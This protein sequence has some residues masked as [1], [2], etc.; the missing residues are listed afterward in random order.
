LQYQAGHTVM[1]QSAGKPGHV[2]ITPVFWAPSGFSFSASYTS[3]IDHYLSDVA[4]ASGTTGNVFAVAT[5]YY[6]QVNGVTQHI[7]YSVSAGSE[8]DVSDPFPAPDAG[9]GCPTTLPA[10][11]NVCVGDAGMRAELAAKGLTADDA[12]MYMVFLPQ[13][14]ETCSPEDQPPVMCSTDP[15][16]P[17]NAF[18][19][20]HSA[21]PLNGQPLVYANMPYAVVANCGD[22]AYGPQAPNG[23][24]FA[25]AEVSVISHEANE[26]ITDW[27]GGT[28]ADAQGLEEGDECAFIFGN[29]LGGS[30][31][32]GSAYNQVINGH[33]YFTQD[34]FSNSDYSFR[35]G[36][37]LDAGVSV[38]VP[39]CV[40]RPTLGTAFTPLPGAATDISVGANG[41]A[42]VIGANTV[43]GG[44]GIYRWN[45]TTWVGVPGGALHIAVDP[46]GNPWVVNSTH[47]IYSWNGGGWVLRPGAANDIAIGGDGSVW[48]IG[49]IAAGGG[50]FGIYGL[51][52]AGWVR[53]SGAG[54]TIGA[55]PDGLPWVINAAHRIFRLTAQV[56]GQNVIFTWVGLPGAATNIGVGDLTAWVIGASPS[57]S[58]N[59]G[60]YHWTGTTWASIP[61]GATVVAAGPDGNP[62]V[63]NAAH[64]IYN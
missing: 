5:Q 46:A 42:W 8:V 21:F 34:E 14:V 15:A 24:Q 57:G 58:G 2:T 41:S 62:W 39:G 60:I 36:G 40:Q 48:V 23:N 56:Q 37:V 3:I 7:Q 33:H 51:A 13:A 53:I 1:G 19:G 32:A 29:P 20:Y 12:H 22:A 16:H 59:F 30:L 9:S 50:N 38:Q 63:I 45:G 18:C 28:W 55:G 10:G 11:Y 54:T 47:Q 43:G 61:G 26:S 6:Q 35:Q 49:T 17:A 52:S 31:Q 27:D 44:H 64:R 25:D 4:A